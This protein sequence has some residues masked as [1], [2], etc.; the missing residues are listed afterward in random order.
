MVCPTALYVVGLALLAS[1]RT[2]FWLA[3]TV[4]EAWFE[5]RPL[6]EAVALLVIEPASMS[7]WVIVCVEV[8]LAEAP[9]ASVP[10]PQGLLVPWSSSATLRGPAGVLFPFL[11]AQSV[12]VML[13]PSL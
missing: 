10:L 9:G 4:K 12:V 1:A 11:V 2:L 6:P 3:V 7:A 13:C 8:Q 5:V